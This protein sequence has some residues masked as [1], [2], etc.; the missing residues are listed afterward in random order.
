MM[1][2]T[3]GR[4]QD[5]LLLPIVS[6]PLRL[7]NDIVVVLVNGLKK[8]TPMIGTVETDQSVRCLLHK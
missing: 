8:S 4:T 3:L 6:L 7:W 5:L 2:M 1:L